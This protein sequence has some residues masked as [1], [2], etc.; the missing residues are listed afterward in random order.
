MSDKITIKGARVHNLKNI[1]VEI[2]KN[3]LVVITGISGS[4]KSSLAF[5]TIYAEGQRKYVESLSAYARQFL[6]VMGKPD[7]D[8]IEG[9]S[10]AIAIDQKAVSK[11]PRSTVGTI[12]EI[13]DY[14]R[15]L[16]ARCG[17]P[18]CPKCEKEVA[19]QTIK[20]ILDQI[21]KLPKKTK[22]NILAP[23]I[24]DRKGEHKHVL[25]E[26]QK[27]G[28]IRVRW[29]GKIYPIEEALDMKVDKKKKHS[30]DVVV[31]R[32]VIEKSKDFET[33][34][35]DSCEAAL[36]LGDGLMIVQN[37]D[38]KKDILFSE[39][40]ACPV[41]GFS[42]PE[43]Q[44]RLFSFNSP[45][46]ACPDC[47]GLGVKQEIDPN[48]VIP[49]PKLSLAEGAIRFWSSTSS[50]RQTW[51]MRFLDALAEEYGFSTTVPVNRLSKKQLKL[52]LYGTGGKPLEVG[53]FYTPFE[54]VIP[55]LERRYK[56][57]SSD[58]VRSEIEK[59]MI[60]KPCPAC[61]GKRL[62]PEALA[63]YLAGSIISDVAT[64]TIDKALS[65]FQELP[66]K[67]TEKEKK[68]AHLILKEII[69]RLTF[70]C[71]VGLD[72][73]TIDRTAA[74]LAG[75]E[76]QRIR[77]A[78]QIG[79]GLSGVIYILDEP[80]I[81]L[82]Q[83]DNTR[84]IETLKG[85]KDLANTVIVVEHD[86]QVINSADH[87][88][89]IGPLAGK[90]GGQVVA[91]GTPDQI[92]KEKTLTGLYLAHKKE[93]PLPK[94]YKRGNG[95]KLTIKG[96]EQFNLKKIDVDIPLGKF[97]C[98]AGVSGSG[99]STLMDEILAKALAKILYHAKQEPGKHK[100][101]LGIENI[102]KVI[103]ID[104]SPIGR[105]PRSNPATYTGLFTYI[106]DLFAQVPEAKIRGYRPGRF[107]FNVKGG[108]CEACQGQGFIR[109]EMQFLPDVFVE[110]DECRGK[111]FNK[112]TLEI[113]YKGKDI[114][115]VLEMTIDEALPFFG[116]IP[117]LKQKLQIL[118]DVGLG[119]MQLGQP[120][121][122]LSG[123]EAQRVKL[124]T[125][126]SRR[127]TGKTLYIL[128]EPTTGLHFDDVKK[129]LDVLGRLVDLGNTV[130]IIEHN[131]DVIKSADWIID[132]GPEG[133][134]KGGY[135]VAEGTPKDIAKVKKSYTGQ[136]L[137][138][139]FKS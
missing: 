91:Q 112:Q 119:Y 6:E 20:Q 110:C 16:F 28:Y 35:A 123:G 56:E 57:T 106:R 12:T 33:R 136:Y 74:S 139:Y 31:D 79:S 89:D 108:R 97:V 122:T 61:K 131:L 118:K 49:N 43:L 109:V 50:S 41:C 7:V 117:I 52:V 22:F 24:K 36:D 55:N 138:K 47:A 116:N 17:H 11:N 67:L 44:P 48:L 25:E 83:R 130:L 127:A 92:K 78:T 18:Y 51:Y 10:P 125:E 23:L 9:L 105:T 77:L 101:I 129:L 86:E 54:G 60:I 39:L 32:L 87:I 34:L 128:D 29:D 3:K 94:E 88:V 2:P 84:L 14:L 64:L 68:I 8:K 93:I 27:A 80:S 70:L 124:A 73:I 133:G 58:Y 40:F 113:H 59:Y 85:L 75:G 95:K 135:L 37:L 72:Y 103:R 1:D 69:H 5:D 53:G 81:G 26:V 137:R 96:A 19:R 132:L 46:G 62:K 13:Y 99:K 42:L 120:A 76:A 121:T 114:A 107:S 104:Q 71:K 65:F 82:H 134:D 30:L 102:D 45:Y 98:I 100:E 90:K 4:G 126:L 111:R 66:K 38:K 115:E 15:L 63:V 21:K